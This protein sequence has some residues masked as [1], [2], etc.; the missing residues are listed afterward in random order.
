M[1]KNTIVPNFKIPPVRVAAD[2][3]VVHLGRKWNDDWSMKN[4][5]EEKYPHVGE[6]V[7]VLRVSSM[8]NFI[9][10]GDL[11]RQAE[12]GKMSDIST[13]S[14]LTPAF[15]QL[16]EQLSRRVTSWNLTDWDGEPLEQPFRR[17]EVIAGLT[18]DELLWL[19]AAVQ[20]E[21]PDIR[22]KD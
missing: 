8:T 1:A 22:K 11:M 3:C 12:S 5:G 6:W 18:E 9:S 20:G 7:E 21:T 15:Q 2:D 16:C 10:I 17:P 4:E 14:H 13:I 19:L